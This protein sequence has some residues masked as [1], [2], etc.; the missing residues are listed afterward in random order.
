MKNI[1]IAIEYGTDLSSRVRAAHL[2]HEIIRL[3]HAERIELNFLGVRTIS[4]SFAD[5]LFGILVKEMGEE[6]FQQHVQVANLA[7]LPRE[8][9]S[10]AIQSRLGFP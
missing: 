1:D 10:D 7:E 2:R 9:M 5:E 8:T 4:D 3:H 6:W